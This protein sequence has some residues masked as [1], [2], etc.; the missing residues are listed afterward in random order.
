MLDVGTGFG[1]FLYVLKKKNKNWKLQAIEPDKNNVKFIMNEL[2]IKTI[3]GF[4]E[5]TFTSNKFNL[6]TLNKVLEHT[7]KPIE[8]LKK[9][10]KNLKTNGEI[11]IEVPDG[12]TASKEGFDREEFFID[13]HYIF[14]KKSFKI[15]LKEA[16]FKIIKIKKIKE[17]SD[18]YTLFAFVR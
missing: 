10:R 1:L 9:L 17:P 15:L 18:K 7:K 5:K 8:V 2:K 14:S 12:E 11:Y 3:H 16:N 4:I 13:H 6:I